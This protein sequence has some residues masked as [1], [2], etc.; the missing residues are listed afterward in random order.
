MLYMVGTTL[1][2][3]H[4]EHQTYPKG[5]TLLATHRE[6]RECPKGEGGVNSV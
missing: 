4:R 2:A 6:H 5:A 3:A 1:L